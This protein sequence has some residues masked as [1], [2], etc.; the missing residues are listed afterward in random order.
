MIESP[1][2][3]FP[4]AGVVVQSV[5]DKH[6]LLLQF[7]VIDTEAVEVTVLAMEEGN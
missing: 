1:D 6:C 2:V 4:E 3:E 7:R 5:Q